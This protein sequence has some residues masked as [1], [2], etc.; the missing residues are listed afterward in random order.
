M[1]FPATACL[2]QDAIGAKKAWG[3]DLSAACCGFL[4]AFVVG[5][6]FVET[7]AHRKVLVIGA[8]KMSSIIDYSDRATCV[9]FGDGAGAVLL[10]PTEDPAL[11]A[12]I[13]GPGEKFLK[14][15]LD[16]MKDHQWAKKDAEGA[17]FKW[18]RSIS[19][20]KPIDEARRELWRAVCGNLISADGTY[21][22]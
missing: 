4:Y 21:K 5:A 10:E 14:A 18:E 7:G 22:A 1:L 20:S 11:T 9:L 19:G 12:L 2:V 13:T 6:K 17:L 15:C 8:D 3:F 16:K